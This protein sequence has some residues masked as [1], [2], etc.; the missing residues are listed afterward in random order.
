[1]ANTFKQKRLNSA[2][3]VYLNLETLA[4]SRDK[5]ETYN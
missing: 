1:M 5:N 2:V 4:I 3:S